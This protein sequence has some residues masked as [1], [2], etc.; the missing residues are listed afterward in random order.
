M[1]ELFEA[2]VNYL[3][4]ILATIAT[5]ALGFLWYGNVFYKPWVA[6][7]AINVDQEEN[8]GPV[9]YLVPLLCALVIA[10]TLA[11]L[12]D[13]TGADSV[14]DCIAIAAFAWVGFAATVQLQQINFSEA[15]VNR[16]QTFLVEGGYTLA[17][18]IVIGAII[19]AFQ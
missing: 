9:I 13:M 11:R 19:G 1:S 17:S 2:D 10:Y 14:G 15:K 8:P 7:R 4:V 6:A 16:L 5:Q 18:F 12:V 3:A